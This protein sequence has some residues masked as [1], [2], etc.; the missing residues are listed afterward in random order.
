MTRRLVFVA[1]TL[2][3]LMGCVR[4]PAQPSGDPPVRPLGLAA[5]VGQRGLVEA[6]RDGASSGGVGGPQAGVPPTPAP[7][8]PALATEA[9]GPTPA[10]VAPST[11]TPTVTVSIPTVAA[12]LAPTPKPGPDEPFGYV[13]IFGP[14]CEVLLDAVPALPQL[15]NL[16]C[17]TAAMRMVLAARGVTTSEEEILAR[18]PRSED[19]HRG[20]R[21]NPEGDG[22]DPE[23]KDYG[24]YAEVVAQVLQSYGVPAQAVQGMSEWELR[25]AVRAGNAAIVWVTAEENPRIVEGDGF[26]LVEGEHV[27]VVVGLLKDGRLLVHDPWGVRADSGREG[28]FPVWA[29]QQWGLFDR[30]AVIV[31]LS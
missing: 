12:T 4:L 13:Q 27:Y 9:A 10:A 17:E 1:V 29:V 28:T 2:L 31:P 19:P 16:S 22:H 6:A 25:Q 20:F 7:D 24:V 14:Q 23:L 26:R 21:G 11:P 30:Q 18:M 5:S 15:R 3:S 8:Q